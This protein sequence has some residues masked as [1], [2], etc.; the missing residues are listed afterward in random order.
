MKS[1][2]NQI[3][4]KV[5]SAS[6]C[7]MVLVFALMFTFISICAGICTIVDF[8]LLSLIA[9]IAS[10]MVARYWFDFLKK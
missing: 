5:V 2:I 6:A 8:D 9:C 1:K 7:I 4:E 3:A 10:A